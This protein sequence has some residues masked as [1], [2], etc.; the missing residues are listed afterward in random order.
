VSSAIVPEA[1]ATAFEPAEGW[2]HY[3]WSRLSHGQEVPMPHP[4]SDLPEG[5]HQEPD[6]SNIALWV[7]VGLMAF[8]VVG[9]L[10]YGLSHPA[11]YASNPPQTVGS[12]ASHPQSGHPM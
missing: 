11:I 7:L 5:E 8:I 9:G 4:H 10:T 1:H 3:G 12:A 6:R 2:N